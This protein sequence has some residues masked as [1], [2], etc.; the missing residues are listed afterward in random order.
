MHG[1]NQGN[2]QSGNLPVEKKNHKE[3]EGVNVIASIFP[4]PVWVGTDTFLI[5]STS[6]AKIA[7]CIEVG[8]YRMVD[9]NGP[10]KP[11]A[12]IQ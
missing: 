12:L 6:A 2:L 10:N 3:A 7:Q 11:Q 5:H 1:I 4:M 8:N 9:G